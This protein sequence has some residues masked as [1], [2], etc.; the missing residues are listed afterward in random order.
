MPNVMAALPEC[1]WRSLFMGRKVWLTRETRLNLQG[2]P[3]LPNRSQPL[4]G[5]RS[6]YYANMRRRHC[7][8]TSFFPIVDTC[9]SCEDTVRQSCA[10][11]PRWPIIF[12]DFLRLVFSASRMQYISDLHPKCTLKAKFHYAI[13]FEAGRR[14]ASNQLRTSFEPASVMEFGFKA[15]PCVEAW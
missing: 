9:L 2:C 10:K 13:C 14:P 1:W 6:P 11:V 4:V 12:G 15:T 5:R 8:L 3:K 7:C